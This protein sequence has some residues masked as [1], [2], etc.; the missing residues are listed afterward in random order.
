MTETISVP[1][2]LVFGLFA[3]WT[4]LDLLR[5]PSV[6]WGGRR[7]TNRM[8]DELNVRLCIGI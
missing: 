4:V 7:G 3:V 1:L 6:H 8:I 5:M 2:R